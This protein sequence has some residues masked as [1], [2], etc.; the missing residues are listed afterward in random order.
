MDA[1]EKKY[2]KNKLRP[3][4]KQKNKN[5]QPEKVFEDFAKKIGE[6]IINNEPIA[7]KIIREKST[8]PSTKTNYLDGFQGDKKTISKQSNIVKPSFPTFQKSF[9]SHGAIDYDFA[10]ME[11]K[12]EEEMAHHEM[13]SHDSHGGGDDGSAATKEGPLN[14]S[15]VPYSG[16]TTVPP[17]GVMVVDGVTAENTDANT[18][19]A[20][21]SGDVYYGPAYCHRILYATEYAPNYLENPGYCQNNLQPPFTGPYQNVFAFSA[22]A[23]QMTLSYSNGTWSLNINGFIFNVYSNDAVNIPTQFGQGIQLLTCP[24]FGIN[25]QN[26]VFT[27][28]CPAY[29]CG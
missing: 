9:V 27:P 28:I 1:F 17:A 7:A 6:I 20:F 24:A 15:P 19:N 12:R 14:P 26:E 5:Q 2:I 13:H 11:A 23:L 29:C 8:K 18:Y 3:S 10:I 22:N 16:P 25:P 4:K 21:T